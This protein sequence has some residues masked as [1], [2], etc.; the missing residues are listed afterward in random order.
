MESLFDYLP[1]ALVV[2]DHQCGE[3]AEARFDMI[4]E[5]Y[6]ARQD[7]MLDASEGNPYR[8]VPPDDI[9]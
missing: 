7:S 3:A 1:G 2:L 9:T 8:P 5:Y 4:S 6:E